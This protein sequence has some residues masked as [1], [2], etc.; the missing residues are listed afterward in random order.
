VLTCG[1]GATTNELARTKKSPCIVG[2]SPLLNRWGYE[3]GGLLD[4]H[5]KSASNG[6]KLTKFLGRQR[7]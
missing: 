5:G 1:G 7:K 6:A 3:V 4:K 2:I